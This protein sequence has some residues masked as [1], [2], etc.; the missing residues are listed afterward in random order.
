M[1]CLCDGSVHFLLASLTWLSCGL[2]IY[3]GYVVHPGVEFIWIVSPL[4]KIFGPFSTSA[5]LYNALDD[6]GVIRFDNGLNFSLVE[7]S[8]DNFTQKV[9]QDVCRRVGWVQLSNGEYFLCPSR[10]VTLSEGSFGLLDAYSLSDFILP[11]NGQLLGHKQP[12]SNV[13]FVL[14]IY[15]RW[16]HFYTPVIGVAVG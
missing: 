7:F 3:S 14:L 5:S 12:P 4:D 9:F 15:F 6:V 11:F 10:F 8:L 2:S 16:C 1:I 13:V